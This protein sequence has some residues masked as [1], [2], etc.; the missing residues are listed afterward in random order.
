MEPVKIFLSVDASYY[1]EIVKEAASEVNFILEDREIIDPD[2]LLDGFSI[3]I[4]L[5]L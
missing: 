5:F 3:G 4:F 2:F 1:K